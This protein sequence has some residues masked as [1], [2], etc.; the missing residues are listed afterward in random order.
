MVIDK[1]TFKNQLFEN[2]KMLSRKTIENASKEQIYEALVFTVRDYVTDM[3][4]KT[5]EQY[6][7]EDVKVVYYLSMEFLMGRFLGNTILNL[8]VIDEIKEILDELNIDYNEL[9]DA[10]RD[11]G[12]GNGGL[13]RLAA[14]FLDSLSTLQLP[15]YGWSIR[16]KQLITGL[17]TGIC[18]ALNAR[19]IPPRLNLWETLKPLKNLM[20]HI[21]LNRKIINRLS[22][23]LTIIRLWDITTTLSIH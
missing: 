3:W 13:G 17:R 20:E 18:G 8:S 11:P 7:K 22:L 1:E 15:A 16:Y 19:S 23:F 2:V 10:E 9:E 14:C 6:Y 12:L 21:N 5:H 4:I